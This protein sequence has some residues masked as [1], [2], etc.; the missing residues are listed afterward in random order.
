MKG[1][2]FVETFQ[3]HFQHVK[4]LG[5]ESFRFPNETEE[6]LSTSGALGLLRL[7]VIE[8]KKICK[9][10][11]IKMKNKNMKVLLNTTRQYFLFNN[12]DFRAIATQITN[13]MCK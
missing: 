1:D 7:S 4:N 13:T 2:G 9:K 10:E 3:T 8:I 12:G 6:A 5:L 11:K